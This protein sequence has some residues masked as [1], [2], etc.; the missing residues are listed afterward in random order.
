MLNINKE[1]SGVK[2][3][4]ATVYAGLAVFPLLRNGGAARDY[5]T[6]AEAFNKRGVEITEV[7]EGGS[8]PHL[9]LKNLLD[10]DLFAADGEALL[11]AK[12]NRVLNTSIFVNA[13]S[14]IKV[15]VSC[16]EQGRWHYQ[17]RNFRASENAEF[18]RSLVADPQVAK[19]L[20]GI[21]RRLARGHDSKSRSSTW[22]DH[23]IEPV[24]APKSFRRW[25][26][27][28]PLTRFLL[29]PRI[30]LTDMHTV[31]R[32]LEVVW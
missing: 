8:V 27:D 3:G 12:Q 30:R 21:K 22:N 20:L 17:D 2:V 1:L 15:P 26:L 11:G 28:A 4:P 14:E 18:I 10:Q 29:G 25:N 16:V 9:Q 6:L 13:K 32:K 7:S 5:V 23:A 31:A 19:G 24:C